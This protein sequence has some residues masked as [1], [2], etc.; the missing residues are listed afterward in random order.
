MRQPF[1]LLEGF[2]TDFPLVGH[3]SRD[4]PQGGGGGACHNCGQEG[5]RLKDCTEPKKIICRNCDEEGHT[6]REC[7]KPRDCKQKLFMR[8]NFDD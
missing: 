7:P 3:F 5:H 6:G 4:C 2:S 1:P 8:N